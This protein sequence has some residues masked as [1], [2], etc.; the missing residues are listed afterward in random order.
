MEKVLR[1]STAG[2]PCERSLW[3]SVNVEADCEPDERRQR[4]FDVG[5]CLEPLIVEWLRRDG[6]EVEYNA[7]SQSA[8]LE[9]NIPLENGRLSGHPDCFISKGSITDCLADIKTMNDRSFTQWKRAGTLKSKPQY[10]DQ[11]HVYALGCLKAGRDIKQL[12]IVGVNKNTSELHIDMFPYDE[13]RA[14]AIV[15]RSDRVLR[16]SEPPLEGCPRESWCCGYCAYSGMCDLYSKPFKPDPDAVSVTSTE[17]EGVIRAMRLLK[18]ARELGKESREQEAEAK[19]LLDSYMK[20]SGTTAV[21]GGG[22]IFRLLERE[23]S[24]FDTT[25]FKK[26]HPELAGKYLKTSASVIYDVQEAE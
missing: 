1:A 23:S 22:L 20:T 2:F 15:E 4:I 17:D 9:L 10:A 6:W 11:L 12:A 24:R 21:Q 25:A 26:E 5:T 16:A 13:A 14:S 19:G 8:P 3:Y 7:G 18:E